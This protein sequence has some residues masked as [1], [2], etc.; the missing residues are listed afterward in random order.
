MDILIVTP[1]GRRAR[2]G[3]RTTAVRWQRLLRRLGHRV[4][5]ATDYGAERADLLIAIHAWRSAAAVERFCSRHPHRPVVVGLGGTDINEFLK[6]DPKTTLATMVAADVLVGL[7]DEVDRAIPSSLH[8]KLRIILQSA[9]PLPKGLVRPSRRSF[10]VA[11]IAHL[12]EVKDPLRAAFAARLL[13]DQSRLRVIHL[14][15][16]HDAAWA[17]RAATEAAANRRYL[18]R[19]EAS[20]GRVRAL[21]GRSRAL[22][23]SS[24]QEGGA[25]VVSEAVVAGVPVIA[26]RIPGNT[27]LLGAD[28][29]GT[30]PVGD[31]G[32]LSRLLNRMETDAGFRRELARHCRARAAR[33]RPQAEQRAWKELLAEL[34]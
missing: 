11:V 7:H 1:A 31:T 33:F 10:D 34:G 6:K 25:N 16:A 27:G 19:G 28:Y 22:V 20:F 32:A 24:L 9:E 23:I 29:P 12:R 18:W 17:A 21:L 5:V 2:T 13:P 14:G 4:A 30:F 15:K 3:N 26:S 8:P